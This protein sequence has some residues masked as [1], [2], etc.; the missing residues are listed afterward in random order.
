MIDRKGLENLLEQGRLVILHQIMT[1]TSEAN[2]LD[3]IET[4]IR[5]EEDDEVLKYF[6]KEQARYRDAILKHH[7][8][9]WTKKSKE[10]WDVLSKIDQYDKEEES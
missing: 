8:N 5:R 10:V 4:Q 9:E 6:I 7:G 3:D 1:R 2:L